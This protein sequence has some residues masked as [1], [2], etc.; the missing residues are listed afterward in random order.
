MS[1][2][3]IAAKSKRVLGLSVT[4]ATVYN[5]LVRYKIPLRSKKISVSMARSKVPLIRLIDVVGRAA[6]KTPHWNPRYW[7]AR[8]LVA[9]KR[10]IAT[11]SLLTREQAAILKGLLDEYG[12]RPAFPEESVETA[13]NEAR[14]LGFPYL[15]P[16]P[17]EQ[18]KSWRRLVKARPDK[19]DGMYNWTGMDTVLATMFH[20]HIYECRKLGKL[21]PLELFNSDEDL[22]RAIRKALC[23]YG[24]VNDRLINDICRN[25]DAAGRVGNFPPRVGKA[26]LAELWPGARDLS[27]LDPCSGFGGRMLACA[28]SGQVGK[29]VGIDLSEKTYAG[30]IAMRDFLDSVKCPMLSDIRHGDCVSEM[31]A[32]NDVFDLVLTS[33]PFLDVEEYVGV[34]SPHDHEEWVHSFVDPLVGKCYSRL[35]NGGKMAIYIDKARTYDLP[36]DFRRAA[37]RE[38]LVQEQSI[39][40][41][42]NYGRARRM[43]AG[44]GIEILVWSKA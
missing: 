9:T 34:T 11:K 26:I 7:N 16:S 27:V 39:F 3:E 17:I 41:R 42:M 33:P 13:F 31:D 22:K 36:G 25:E 20:P 14:K 4:P 21:S 29:Y 12:D 24:K 10:V 18:E 40:F 23:L 30:L 35:K 1:T 37:S 2:T 43:E 6:S 32:V 28:A 5:Y 15:I 38:G 8:W 44:K 19:K